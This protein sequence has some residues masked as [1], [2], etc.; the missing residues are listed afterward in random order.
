MLSSL[1]ATQ[2]HTP[3]HPQ[4]PLKTAAMMQKLVAA[5]ATHAEGPIS[6]DPGQFLKCPTQ[7]KEHTELLAPSPKLRAVG[8]SL[9]EV[10]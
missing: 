8:C 5:Q 2:A 4:A 10:Q 7:G 3:H 6:I 9:Q 1:L